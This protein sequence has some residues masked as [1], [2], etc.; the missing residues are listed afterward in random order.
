MGRNRKK[1]TNPNLPRTSDRNHPPPLKKPLFFGRT[2]SFS[3]R[4]ARQMGRVFRMG[5]SWSIRASPGAFS[6]FSPF[7]LLRL[8]FFGSPAIAG[9][10]TTDHRPTHDRQHALSYGPPL[11]ADM[12]IGARWPAAATTISAVRRL[13]APCQSEE[14]ILRARTMSGAFWKCLQF[15]AV[16][17]PSYEY[18]Q[19][20]ME[21]YS[22]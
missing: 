5:P 21:K 22:Y 14:G 11:K 13:Q 2:Y 1:R 12:V 18:G 16:P 3:D 8:Q 20:L 9:A 10:P 19:N 4:R 15:H 6:P 7:S 17:M